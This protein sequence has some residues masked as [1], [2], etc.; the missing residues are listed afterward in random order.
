[1]GIF[2]WS[3]L[4]GG[5]FIGKYI[6][7]IEKVDGFRWINFDF[8]LINKDKVYDIIDVMVEIV[9]KYEV[10]VVCV[11]FVWLLYKFGVISVIIGVRKML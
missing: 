11:V 9:E 3:L 4:V 7:E 5:F 6:R 8:F 1:M 10:M 2:L